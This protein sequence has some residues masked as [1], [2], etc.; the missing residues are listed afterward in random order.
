[1][2]TSLFATLL[3]AISVVAPALASPIGYVFITLNLA[4]S[5]R[6]FVAFAT[7]LTAAPHLPH[8]TPV[9]RNY[10]VALVPTPMKSPVVRP[11]KI[12]SEE[13]AARENAANSRA[14]SR[15]LG[16]Q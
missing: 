7:A 2:R 9:R 11:T 5:T 15:V 4:I 16:L 12:W 14:S 3:L 8:A 6:L 10:L 1:M 13:F